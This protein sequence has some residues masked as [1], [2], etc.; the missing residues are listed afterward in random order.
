MLIIDSCYSGVFITH[1]KSQLSELYGKVA[2]LTAA[3]KTRACYYT[4]SEENG[5][6]DFFTHSLLQGIGYKIRIENGVHNRYVGG[7]PA[8]S[9]KT[10]NGMVTLSEFF[11]YGNTWT[12]KYVKKY[13][14]KSVLH[15]DPKQKPQYYANELGSLVL[16]GS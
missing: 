5:A 1:M 7:M 3:K 8:D 2:V 14:G 4:G 13:K 12:K 10:R 9:G 6:C 15:G 16:F 11:N